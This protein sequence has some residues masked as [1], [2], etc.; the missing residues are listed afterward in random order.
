[1]KHHAVPRVLAAA[2][3]A[4][5]V[6][7]ASGC[8]GTDTGTRS[9]GSS[10]SSASSTTTSTPDRPS[11]KE[12]Y[13]ATR[14][15]A[16][17]AKSARVKGSVTSDNDKVSLD[18]RGTVDGKNQTAT[19]ESAANGGKITVVTAGGKSWLQA[20]RSFWTKNAD[21]S[22][23]K[24][25]AG[26]YVAM[27]AKELQG[28]GDLTISSLLN[29]MFSDKDLSVLANLASKV[30][31][32]TVGGQQVYVLTDRGDDTTEIVVSADGKARLMTIRTGGA[33]AGSLE[34]SEWDAAPTVSAP[35]AKDVVRP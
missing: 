33:E 19:I 17:A 12:L 27:S 29:E 18:L 28:F 22:A 1:M 15:A 34:F 23:A 16:L 26:K 11:V 7:I 3:T 9:T 10:G 32:R 8:G 31:T 35:P 21:A 4:S 5:L 2:A 6:L 13:A 14:T 30:E 25:L 24:T 20:D